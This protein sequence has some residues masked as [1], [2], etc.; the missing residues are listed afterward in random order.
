MLIQSGV[1]LAY[2][3]SLG[4]GLFFG[5]ALLAGLRR[6]SRVLLL[7]NRLGSGEQDHSPLLPF[8]WLASNETD[9][10]PWRRLPT[11]RLQIADRVSRS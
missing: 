1:Y 4:L 11:P 5:A 3:F 6:E 9:R 2:L 7:T 10:P 8:V